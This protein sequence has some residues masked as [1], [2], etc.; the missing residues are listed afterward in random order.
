L[1]RHLFSG[2]HGIVF[3]ITQK[4]IQIASEFPLG[5]GP[6]LGDSK[7]SMHQRTPLDEKSIK[8]IIGH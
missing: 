1:E 2:T 6:N 7:H 8:T 4:T 3:I 5:K